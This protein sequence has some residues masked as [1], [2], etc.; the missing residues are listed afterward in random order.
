MIETFVNV[1]KAILFH[2]D[3]SQSL[4][5]ELVTSSTYD[6]SSCNVSSPYKFSLSALGWLDKLKSK[7]KWSKSMNVLLILKSEMK[8]SIHNKRNSMYL[9]TSVGNNSSSI[10]LIGSV[11]S[12]SSS[13][14]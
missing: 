1:A 12:N 5:K 4:T 7:N 11:D 10:F 9:S 3:E 13:L 6:A 14:S 2:I 8:F